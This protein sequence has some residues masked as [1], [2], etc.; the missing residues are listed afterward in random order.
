M[1]SEVV[2]ARWEGLPLAV[3][4]IMFAQLLQ[5]V[6]AFVRLRTGG[7]LIWKLIAFRRPRSRRQK[8]QVGEGTAAVVGITVVASPSSLPT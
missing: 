2:L 5:M 3:P 4:P 1:T 7:T 6:R 8:C